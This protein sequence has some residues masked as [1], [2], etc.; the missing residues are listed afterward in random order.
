MQAIQYCERCM[1]ASKV[2]GITEDPDLSE[3]QNLLNVLIGIQT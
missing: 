1:G 3:Y 2:D